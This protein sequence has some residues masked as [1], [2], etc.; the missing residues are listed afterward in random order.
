M[1][2]AGPDGLAVA[3]KAEDGASRPLGPALAAFLAPLGLDLPRLA[4]VSLRNGTGTL[5]GEIATASP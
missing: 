5:V 2:A 3:L 4:T 1:C